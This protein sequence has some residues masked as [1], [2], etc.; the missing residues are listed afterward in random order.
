[1]TGPVANGPIM[2][3]PRIVRAQP[4][5]ARP[6]ASLIAAAFHVLAVSGWLVPDPL[7]RIR[8]LPAYFRIL[9]GHALGHGQVHLTSDR[10][11]AAVWLPRLD[12]LPDPVYYN[13]RLATACGDTAPRFQTLDEL[14]AKHHPTK[15][16]HHLA[17]LAVVPHR[18]RTGL[19]TAL[20]RH[21]HQQLD[22]DGIPAYVEAS[23]PHSRDLYTRHGYQPSEP[24][25]LPD[26][27][28]LWSMWRD[29]HNEAQA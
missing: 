27:P 20:L 28:P 16:H 23:S 21:H 5:D 4:S 3:G 15:P 10:T 18:Q 7:Q 26:G 9:V 1:M 6:V 22:R 29:P 11:A 2:N 8:I 12:P 24:F 25:H 17:L 19:G 13:T 14:F